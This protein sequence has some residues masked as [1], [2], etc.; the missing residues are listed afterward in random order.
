MAFSLWERGSKVIFYSTIAIWRA[1]T[2]EKLVIC[3]Q[4]LTTC[5]CIEAVLVLPYLD[6]FICL[7][8]IPRLEI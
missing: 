6:T 8:Y 4:P 1:S 2:Q 3:E 5:A 7:K